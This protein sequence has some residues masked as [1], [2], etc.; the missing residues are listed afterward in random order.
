MNDETFAREAC[1]ALAV[2]YLSHESYVTMTSH[3]VWV[4]VSDGW[5]RY[6]IILKRERYTDDMDRDGTSDARADIRAERVRQIHTEGW[7]PEHDD[8]HIGD[9]RIVYVGRKG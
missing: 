3:E 9:G 2:T 1:R 4:A 8:Q 6:E 5:E 7:M